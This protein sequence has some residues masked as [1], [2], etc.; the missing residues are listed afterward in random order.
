MLIFKAA[1]IFIVAVSFFTAFGIIGV[2]VSRMTI[3]MNPEALAIL[4]SIVPYSI[5][6]AMIASILFVVQE[7]NRRTE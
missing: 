7:W 6:A 1:V 2:E 3:I 4:K 5:S